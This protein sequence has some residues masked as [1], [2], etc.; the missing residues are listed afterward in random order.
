MSRVWSA[1]GPHCRWE[2][3]HRMTHSSRL[4]P[5]IEVTS[6]PAVLSLQLLSAV[7]QLVLRTSHVVTI[8]NITRFTDICSGA[9]VFWYCFILSG[10]DIASRSVTCS[11]VWRHASGTLTTFTRLHVVLYAA[12]TQNIIER[13]HLPRMVQSFNFR[14][15][16]IIWL[17]F[18]YFTLWNLL[19]PNINYST[20]PCKRVVW[21][22]RRSQSQGSRPQPPD[23]A[24]LAR[25]F[26]FPKYFLPLH[27]ALV[28]RV[29]VV[30]PVAASFEGSLTWNC[31]RTLTRATE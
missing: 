24:T 19:K 12:Q 21:L 20:I 10:A 22:K 14:Y 7:F 1:H 17:I 16:K 27:T 18:S 5:E 11:T 2:L 23:G 3:S 4:H 6:K 15:I 9:Y 29:A 28:V 13:W 30:R 8:I 31:W 26:T 25:Q